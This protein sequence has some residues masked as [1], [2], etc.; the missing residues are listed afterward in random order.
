M[1]A[2]CIVTCDRLAYTRRCIESWLDTRRP[3]DRLVIVDNAS[4][5]GTADYLA[6]LPVP[7]IYNETNRYPG[8]ACNQGWDWLVANVNAI[9]L[10]R[11]DNDIEYLPGWADE[12]EAAFVR[13][14]DLVL[15]GLLNLHEDLGYEP[16]KVDIIESVEWLG[17]NVV[18]PTAA[19]LD[20]LRWDERPWAPGATEDS[21]MSAWGH[22]RGGV[23]RLVRTVANNMAFNRYE[24]FPAYYDRTAAVRGLADARRSV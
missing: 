8:A 12:A 9:Y 5:D 21:H 20:G 22:R 3:G 24:D 17:G 16:S 11:S 2:T 13:H 23:A 10:H 14:P 15:L 7:T 18:M 6:T 1:I 4:T 19:F